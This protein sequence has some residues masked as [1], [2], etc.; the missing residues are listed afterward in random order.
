M[1]KPIDHYFD[2]IRPNQ[3]M[4]IRKFLAQKS[5]HIISAGFQ[6]Q[7]QTITVISN[8]N[9][10][11]TEKIESKPP[12]EVTET[13]LSA[14]STPMLGL[15]IPLEVPRKTFRNN[16]DIHNDPNITEMDASEATFFDANNH[17]F[18]FQNIAIL[19]LSQFVRTQIEVKPYSVKSFY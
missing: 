5:Q 12:T 16:A 6:S 18:I 8:P 1:N 19:T 15:I 3:S 7:S 14:I 17:Q 10:N 11:N 4:I 13:S 9:T 2:E